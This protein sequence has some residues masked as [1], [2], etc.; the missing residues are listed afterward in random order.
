MM[1]ERCMRQIDR[2]NSGQSLTEILY[3]V[4]EEKLQKEIRIQP[5]L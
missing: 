1:I 3:F 5:S 2:K 4:K